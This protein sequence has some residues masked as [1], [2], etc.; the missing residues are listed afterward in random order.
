MKRMG[1]ENGDGLRPCT[2]IRLVGDELNKNG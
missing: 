2:Q 1:T